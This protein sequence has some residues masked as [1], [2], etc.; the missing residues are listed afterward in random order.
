M[1]INCRWLPPPDIWPM[2]NRTR[3]RLTMLLEL[4]E[5]AAGMPAATD[6][7]EVWDHLGDVCSRMNQP[8]EAAAAWQK[9][10]E[11]S[12]TEKVTVNDPRGAEV[13]R[14]LKRLHRPD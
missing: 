8:A 2:A 1:P 7:A 6:V 12:R 14:K 13:E 4:I 10:L 11:L 9:A 3:I 5:R